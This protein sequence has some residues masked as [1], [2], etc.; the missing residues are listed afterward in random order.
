MLKYIKETDQSFLFIHQTK[1]GEEKPVAFS[2][3]LKEKSPIKGPKP[4][5][6]RRLINSLICRCKNSEEKQKLIEKSE[7]M[8]Q[9][10]KSPID[11]IKFL[12]KQKSIKSITKKGVEKCD[13]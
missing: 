5:E 13:I 3:W 4:D 9:S 11:I 10:G 6:W 1:S 7:K 12:T 2:T 8:R